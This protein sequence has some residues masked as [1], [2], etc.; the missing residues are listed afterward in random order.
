MKTSVQVVV[1]LK[2]L[3]QAAHATVDHD[4]E[5]MIEARQAIYQAETDP[6][7]LN[8]TDQLA[9]EAGCLYSASL[10]ELAAKLRR[11]EDGSWEEPDGL[12]IKMLEDL[13]QCL[14]EQREDIRGLEAP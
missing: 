2:K 10:R 5:A 7:I 4:H 1:A 14:D 9:A 12:E 3:Y 8:R 6:E 13:A 11:I